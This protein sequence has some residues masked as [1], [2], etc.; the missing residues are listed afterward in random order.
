MGAE[1]I[2]PVQVW[3][4]RQIA[5]GAAKL[6]IWTKKL[7]LQVKTLNGVP[8]MVLVLERLLNQLPRWMLT[9]EMQKGI[10]IV[11][12]LTILFRRI[13]LLVEVKL[14]LVCI[15]GRLLFCSVKSK[16]CQV[17]LAEELSLVTSTL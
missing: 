11:E 13:K 12:F 2:M 17:K 7:R 1:C 6:R 3:T 9:Q 5:E 15:L 14:R 10:A 4:P 16:N 8:M